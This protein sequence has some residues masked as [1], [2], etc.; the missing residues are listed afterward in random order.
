MR[1]LR[2][3]ILIRPIA[4]ERQQH[5]L[6]IPETAKRPNYELYQGTV[7]AVG[8]GKRRKFNGA[9][10]PTEVKPGDHVMYYW[11][12]AKVGNKITVD[13]EDLPIITEEH[14]QGVML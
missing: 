6:W 2:D 9:L 10:M 5:G 4:P 3:Q 14:V 1:L 8:P 11:V 7:L 12:A 13:G